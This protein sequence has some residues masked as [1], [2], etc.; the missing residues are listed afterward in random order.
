MIDFWIRNGSDWNID[1]IESQYVNICTYRPLSGSIYRNFF[2]W[3]KKSKKRS[4]QYQYQRSKML[5]MFP[6]WTHYTFKKTPKNNLKNDK[7]VVEKLNF[8]GIE[9]P[10]QETFFNKTEVKNKMCINVFGYE[11]GLLFPTD[12]SGQTFGDSMDFLLLTEDDS[13]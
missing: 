2:S 6:C 12:V 1:L 10:G 8:V 4:N 9:Y 7:K 11:N 5:F 13:Q 3:T